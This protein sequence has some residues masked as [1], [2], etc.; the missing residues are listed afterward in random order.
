MSASAAGTK[1]LKAPGRGIMVI[2]WTE[3][4]MKNFGEQ[5]YLTRI[6]HEA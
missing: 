5:I 2:F 1:V 6:I 4:F 3:S